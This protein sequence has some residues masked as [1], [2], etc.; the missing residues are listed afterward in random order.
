MTEILNSAMGT[1]LGVI[2]LLVAWLF[3][4]WWFDTRATD[5]AYEND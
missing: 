2:V 1:V 3:F 4:D 5:T